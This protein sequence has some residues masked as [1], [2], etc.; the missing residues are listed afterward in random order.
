[1][2]LQSEN[3]AEQTEGNPAVLHL[4]LLPGR[5]LGFNNAVTVSRCSAPR[6]GLKE[7]IDDIAIHALDSKTLFSQRTT[8][9][10]SAID[11]ERHDP[12]KAVPAFYGK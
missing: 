11:L 4:I 7:R 9:L 8:G 2:D 10:M 6:Q 5:V 12:A 1:M 3:F